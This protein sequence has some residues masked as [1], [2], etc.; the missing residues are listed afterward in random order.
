MED[1]GVIVE[2]FSNFWPATI[3]AVAFTGS[4]ILPLVVSILKKEIDSGIIIPVIMS[5]VMVMGI[6]GIASYGIF[7]PNHQNNVVSIVEEH[8]DVS[9]FNDDGEKIGGNGVD[10]FSSMGHMS[11]TFKHDG[12]L[13]TD[14]R[15][16]I[17]DLEDGSDRFVLLFNPNEG[18]DKMTEFSSELLSNSEG[19]DT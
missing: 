4:V 13:F 3:V 11:V 17:D 9:L 12:E 1:M 19:A 15:L 2:G 18:T 7:Y 10:S 6:A 8:Y 5:A 14:G 16:K